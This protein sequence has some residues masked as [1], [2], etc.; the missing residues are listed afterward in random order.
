[1]SE[2]L[3]FGGY[4]FYVLSSYLAAAVVIVWELAMLRTRIERA[5]GG[6]D[7]RQTRKDDPQ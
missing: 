3:S 6:L 2:L 1:M 4:G 7:P 5:K